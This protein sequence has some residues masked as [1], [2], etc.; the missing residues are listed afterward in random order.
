MSA[1]AYPGEYLQLTDP[2]EEMLSIV[3]HF[4][5]ATQATIQVDYVLMSL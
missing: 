3:K 2:P 1:S 4:V 5:V